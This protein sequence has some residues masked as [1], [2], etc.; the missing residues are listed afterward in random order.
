MLFILLAFECEI[1]NHLRNGKKTLSNLGLQTWHGLMA[2]KRTSRLFNW[3]Q[4]LAQDAIL[5]A[6]GIYISRKDGI[7]IRFAFQERL[8]S[9]KSSF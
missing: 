6:S 5:T 4:S 3:L 1:Y 7:S 9:M 2:G 8:D